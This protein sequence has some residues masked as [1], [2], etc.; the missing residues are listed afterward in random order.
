MTARS[1]RSLSRVEIYARVQEWSDRLRVRPAPGKPRSVVQELS[2]HILSRLEAARGVGAEA[3]RTIALLLP[4]D[5]LAHPV[6]QLR[7]TTV[8][9]ARSVVLSRAESPGVHAVVVRRTPALRTAGSPAT[10]RCAMSDPPHFASTRGPATADR[11][12]RAECDRTRAR[13]PTAPP[14]PAVT[15]R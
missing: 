2:L 5:R 6:A 4:R 7:T 11:D 8:V 1:R 3:Y 14:H 15:A 10:S 12:A 9:T 13:R